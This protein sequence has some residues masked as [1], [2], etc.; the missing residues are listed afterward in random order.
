[1]Y[2]PNEIETVVTVQYRTPDGV[3]HETLAEALEHTPVYRP[4]YKLWA[5][6]GDEGVFETEDI[7]LAAFLYCP[8]TRSVDDFINDSQSE[9]CTVD[10]IDG[11]GLYTWDLNSYAW[12]L[13][14]EGTIS[15]FENFLS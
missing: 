8:D 12:V 13:M 11:K 10:G 9:G 7:N 14:P 4:K 15:L 1:M 5:V 6:N 2:N 3:V